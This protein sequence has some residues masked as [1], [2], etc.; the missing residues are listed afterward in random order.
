MSQKQVIK[1][2]GRTFRTKLEN[3]DSDPSYRTVLGIYMYMCVRE[4]QTESPPPPTLH[5]PIHALAH[6]TMVG[7]FNWHNIDYY[8]TNAM[9]VQM[10]K[11]TPNRQVAA[12]DVRNFID[13]VSKRPSP[14][15]A[16]F[17]YYYPTSFPDERGHRNKHKE[18]VTEFNEM[19][20]NSLTPTEERKVNENGV[21]Y[22]VPQLTSSNGATW[23][24]LAVV[25]VPS[26]DTW[27]SLSTTDKAKKVL[28]VIDSLSL[29]KIFVYHRLTSRTEATSRVR[30]VAWF[31]W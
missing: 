4:C 17:R 14:V 13:V 25:E 20:A 28:V 16:A 6:H 30:C 21:I 19:V 23:N 8:P 27:A 31:E 3:D 26:M 22:R 15:H 9:R 10:L 12:G 24:P 5:H 1:L 18:L 2:A 7:V 29:S 11:G